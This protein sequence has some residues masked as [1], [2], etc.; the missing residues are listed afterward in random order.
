MM[1]T[2][3]L[4][5]CLGGCG[6]RASGKPE[7]DSTTGGSKDAFIVPDAPTDQAGGCTSS[8]SALINTCSVA[9]DATISLPDPANCYDY[10][11]DS[12]VLGYF[13]CG[14]NNHVVLATLPTHGANG[15]DFLVLGSFTIGS[16]VSFTVR[17]AKPFAVVSPGPVTI[18]GTLDVRAGRRTAGQCS[19][20]AGGNGIPGGSGGGGGGGGGYGEG[21][22]GGGSGQQ[23]AGAGGGGTSL[24]S[25][26]VGGCPGG[27]GGQGNAGGPAPGGT[28]GG[29]VYIA[30]ISQI[31]ISGSINAGGGGGTGGSGDSNSTGTG[32]RCGGGGGGSGGMVW[33][34]A[35]AMSINGTVAANGG[36]GG[37]G[38]GN[39]LPG[40]NGADGRAATTRAP[41]GMGQDPTGG[42][43]G[44]GGTVAMA[45]STGASSSDGGGGG[46]GGGGFI[47]LV[48]TRTGNGSVSPPAL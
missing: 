22:R 19:A 34:E 44:A 16:N 2:L 15:V 13:V 1:K 36:G 28:G 46:G 9:A 41:G 24:P 42:D 6:F 40:A 12:H 25:T 11:T 7:P 47:H 45:P 38:S 37:E 29:V 21:G 31:A 17:G 35:P 39:T 23:P 48:G 14:D 26:L 43:G 3:A 5:V 8:F 10:N 27:P 33:L 20:S 30:A 32:F 18:D 4:V